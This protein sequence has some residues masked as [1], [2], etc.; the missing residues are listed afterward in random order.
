MQATYF[1]PATRKLVRPRHLDLDELAETVAGAS[2]QEQVGLLSNNENHN[3]SI[4]NYLNDIVDF[5][6]NIADCINKKQELRK[7]FLKLKNN[8]KIASSARKYLANCTAIKEGLIVDAVQNGNILYVTTKNLYIRPNTY[9]GQKYKRDIGVFCFK[10]YLAN[11]DIRIFNLTYRVQVPTNSYEWYDHPAVK[12]NMVCWSSWES[13]ATEAMKTK[14][15]DV[16]LD[17][18]IDFLLAPT[19]TPSGSSS[20]AY[21]QWEQW[22]ADRVKLTDL[23]KKDAPSSTSGFPYDIFSPPSFTSLKLATRVKDIETIFGLSDVVKLNFAKPIYEL[24]GKNTDTEL[25]LLF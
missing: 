4:A 14:Q 8:K 24:K 11:K 17:L 21:R 10:I 3:K 2:R 7:K 20:G 12:N 23:A 18:L 6:R 13:M 1:N 15:L 22:F 19:K 9:Q 5:Q 25:D 16:L